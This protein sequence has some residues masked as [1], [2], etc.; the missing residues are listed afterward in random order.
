MA[1]WGSC[2]LYVRC[3]LVA[4]KPTREQM[5]AVT[6][7]GLLYYRFVSVEMRFTSDDSCATLLSSLEGTTDDNLAAAALR[8]T[9]LLHNKILSQQ[10]IVAAP[11]FP[12]LLKCIIQTAT[13][14]AERVTS[15]S[16]MSDQAVVSGVVSL[17]RVLL[18]ECSSTVDTASVLELTQTILKNK[19]F[20]SE[21]F[22]Q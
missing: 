20:G 8:I 10:P 19:I 15:S 5:V 6:F 18:Q 2:M 21:D 4:A 7:V 12:P 1:R 3:T 22:G 9:N 14:S 17:I 13:Q 16:A 11:A